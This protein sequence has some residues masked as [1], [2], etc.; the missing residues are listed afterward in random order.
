MARPS[1]A[2]V[3]R[4]ETFPHPV[5]LPLT[6]KELLAYAD[7]LTALDTKER[8][9]NQRHQSEKGKFKSEV[10]EI[11]QQKTITLDFLRTK[12]G[13]KDIECYNFFDHFNGICEIRRVDNDKV[14][15]TRKM[16][17]KEYRGERLFKEEEKALAS[18]EATDGQIIG[19]E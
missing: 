17:E 10:E 7:E 19:D 4:G 8:E 9:V 11:G 16:T 15:T 6:D 2:S 3:V 13:Y 1:T 5:E 18:N 12:K 14:V